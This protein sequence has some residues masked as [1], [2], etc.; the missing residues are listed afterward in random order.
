M[1]KYLNI[2]FA[3]AMTAIASGVFYREFT[4]LQ[5]FDGRTALAFTHLHLFALGTLVFLLLALFS[6]SLDLE[7]QK[8]FRVFLALY[9]VGL[10]FMVAMFY[11]RGILLVLGTAL[12]AG[13]N[14]AVSGVSGIAHT[15][16]T[17]ALVLLFVSLRR[18]AAEKAASAN[19]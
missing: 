6:Q 19:G 14:A 9:N 16:L 13:A 5:G 1:K 2:A 3:Y 8:S 10:P 7:K 12:S 17:V 15:I 11:V 4:K 18:A